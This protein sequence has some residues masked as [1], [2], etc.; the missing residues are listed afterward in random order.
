MDPRRG[1]LYHSP[2]LHF[3]FPTRDRF[4]KAFLAQLAKGGIAVECYDPDAF[5]VRT[6][7][8]GLYNLHNFH[9]EFCSLGVLGRL[10]YLKKLI[11][12]GALK[13]NDTSTDWA[14]ASKYILPTVKHKTIPHAMTLQ[15]ELDSGKHAQVFT[16]IAPLG[17]SLYQLLCFDYPHQMAFSPFYDSTQEHKVSRETAVKQSLDNLWDRSKENWKTTPDGLWVS[18]WQDN[19]DS[20]R[21]ALPGLI[22]QLRVQGRH[23]A[24]T[25]NRDYLMVTG[26]ENHAGIQTML[27]FAQTQLKELPR[28]SQNPILLLTENDAWT[29]YAPSVGDP[30][31]DLL[32]GWNHIAASLIYFDLH[33]L[34]E[35]VLKHRG[36]D[37]TVQPLMIAGEEGNPRQVPMAL[38]MDNAAGLLPKAPIVTF[39]MS[40][41]PIGCASWD[42]VMEHAA[43]CL[44]KVPDISPDYWRIIAFPSGEVLAKMGVTPDNDPW[45]LA[46]PHS[47][48]SS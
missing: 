37:T 17:S 8:S 12:S 41:K 13:H 16:N 48:V 18:P 19:Q 40:G 31:F 35:R 29:D 32:A 28:S 46:K 11:S 23:I 20:A 2:M 39:G 6:K 9:A 43:G 22:R 38:W 5:S 27:A 34:V 1:S 45:E 7:P 47:G 15:I 10:S 25:V 24:L 33:D 30:S 4:A 44:E 14:E 36:E 3:F 21:L 42:A 26:T